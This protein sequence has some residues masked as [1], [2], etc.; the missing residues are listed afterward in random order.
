MKI[1]IT[2][3]HKH[4][5]E[6]IEMYKRQPSGYKAEYHCPIASAARDVSDEFGFVG[7]W[8]IK[9]SGRYLEL[10]EAAK[11]FVINFDRHLAN[12]F[13]YCPEL[14]FSIELETDEHL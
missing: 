5:D 10:P 3:K 7:R 13:K 1:T 12:N 11:S 8:Y 6:A 2:V 9:Y 14:P 4:F